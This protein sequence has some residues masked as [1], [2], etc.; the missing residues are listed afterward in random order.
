MGACGAVKH[1]ACGR[2][3]HL[4]CVDPTSPCILI[5]L[6]S[7]PCR[8]GVVKY[9]KGDHVINM[10]DQHVKSFAQRKKK[11][12][13]PRIGTCAAIPLLVPSVAFR[14][15]AV[16]C[17]VAAILGA[18]VRSVRFL[19]SP[20]LAGCGT[21]RVENGEYGSRAHAVGGFSLAESS[22]FA[23]A[24]WRVPTDEAYISWDGQ[25]KFP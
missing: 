3:K 9:Y 7:Q 19:C 22:L 25:R 24:V 2:T 11:S 13:R 4:V 14:P 18:A 21:T 12:R 23:A 20:A 5:A 6:A 10:D 17:A 8:Y 1:R 15:C 16:A